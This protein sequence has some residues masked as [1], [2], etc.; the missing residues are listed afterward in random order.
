MHPEP[1][2]QECLPGLQPSDADGGL[3]MTASE[4]LR[5]KLIDSGHWAPLMIAMH[6]A[7][8]EKGYD[9]IYAF[10]WKALCKEVENL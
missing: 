3:L 2:R 6:A 10:T 8:K 1:V 7:W 4:R 5:Q 9:K